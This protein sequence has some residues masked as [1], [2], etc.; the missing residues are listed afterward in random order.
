MALIRAAANGN[1]SSSST[2]TGGI[3]PGN[4][5]TVLSNG[6]NVT[7]DTPVTIGGANNPSVNAGSF[8][9]SQFYQIT[10][11]GTTNFLSHGATSNTVG[12]I[13]QASNAGSGTGTAIARATITNLILSG[14]TAGGGFLMPSVQT[15]TTDIRA[16]TL[17]SALTL[18][19][20]TGTLSL[21]NVLIIVGT[22]SAI[23]GINVTSTAGLSLTGCTI[24]G[25]SSSGSGA[26]Y[27]NNASTATITVTNCALNSDG[28]SGNS[29]AINNLS[30]GSVIVSGSSL[31]GSNGAA[32]VV[33]NL[34][35]G[36]VTLSGCTLT[37]TAT[38]N[39]LAN[40]STGSVT[41]SGCTITTSSVAASS[42]ILANL[43]TGNFTITSSTLYASNANSAFV[44]SNAAANVS[45]SGILVGSSN[46]YPAVYC[47]KW[48]VGTSPTGSYIVQSLNGSTTTFTWYG[49]DFSGF[50]QPSIADVRSGVS[51]ALGGLTGTAVIPSPSSVAYGVNVDATTGTA[52][53]TPSAVQA[54]LLPLL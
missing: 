15:L 32:G 54:A 50:G 5:D 33:S 8:I 40:T 47:I 3:L 20:T 28:G 51:Y 4:G 1:W 53:L 30:S 46:G 35:T 23:H 6:F 11:V 19:A 13:F 21:S 38:R 27:I 43:S 18:S 2:W 44:G 36:S 10:S 49:A 12:T 42:P 14:S 37:A 48:Q 24:G 34:A 45:I 26:H 39:V 31:V 16:G 52:V 9:A 17:N 25:A 29:C 7:I 22:G 41:I